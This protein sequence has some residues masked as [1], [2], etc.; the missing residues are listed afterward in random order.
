M[1]ITTADQLEL[2]L[3]RS[4]YAIEALVTAPMLARTDRVILRIERIGLSYFLKLLINGVLV[5]CLPATTPG[6]LM[7]ALLHY[8]QFPDL[9][10]LAWEY[11]PALQPL[12]R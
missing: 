12:A 7:Q 11:A 3:M 6:W 4:P 2:V 8:F 1:S 9:Y 5:F 10:C